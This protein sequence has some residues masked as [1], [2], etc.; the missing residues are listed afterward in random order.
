MNG[1]SGLAVFSGN[2]NVFNAD[3][4]YD[5]HSGQ[6][7]FREEMQRGDESAT[8]ASPDDS[9]LGSSPRKPN[10]PLTGLR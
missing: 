6:F 8:V 7:V 5:R 2:F 3:G 10:G 9:L 4:I 1:E